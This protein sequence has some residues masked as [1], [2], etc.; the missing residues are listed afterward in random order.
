MTNHEEYILLYI[1]NLLLYIG[2]K[3]YI[4]LIYRLNQLSIYNKEID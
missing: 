3:I 4:Y 2:F 1:N